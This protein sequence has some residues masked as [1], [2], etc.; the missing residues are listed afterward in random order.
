MILLGWGMLP[1]SVLSQ[2]SF[3][4]A[5]TDMLTTVRYVNTPRIS[6]LSYINDTLDAAGRPAPYIITHGG[7]DGGGADG[8]GAARDGDDGDGSKGDK[9]TGFRRFLVA[10]NVVGVLL[11]VAG[12]YG[13]VVGLSIR[14][15]AIGTLACK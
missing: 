1:I 6:F 12:V 7:D 9:P 2:V 4:S 11:I 13:M 15:T 10:R 8:T 5:K 14:P 3:T